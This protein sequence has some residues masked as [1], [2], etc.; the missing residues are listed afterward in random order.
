MSV[1]ASKEKVLASVQRIIN[2]QGIEGQK[3]LTD[4]N[5][6][7]IVNSADFSLYLI[8]ENGFLVVKDVFPGRIYV[9]V[10]IDIEWVF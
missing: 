10:K 2:E 5:G 1:K 6:H 4:E 9:K 7:D 3:Y 8:Q